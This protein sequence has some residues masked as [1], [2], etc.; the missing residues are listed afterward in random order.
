MRINFI[1]FLF[2]SERPTYLSKKTNPKSKLK[3]NEPSNFLVIPG[4]NLTQHEELY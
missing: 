2:L 1:F 4:I 3:S